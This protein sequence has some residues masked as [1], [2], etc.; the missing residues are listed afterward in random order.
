MASHGPEGVL[1]TPRVS[2]LDP[3]ENLCIGEMAEKKAHIEGHYYKGN[4]ICLK[5]NQKGAS[6][7]TAFGGSR[8]AVV[9]VCS[10]LEGFVLPLAH[11]GS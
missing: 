11:S 1:Q 10:H 4:K 6:V 9:K 5:S 7:F 2:N 3:F 8:K